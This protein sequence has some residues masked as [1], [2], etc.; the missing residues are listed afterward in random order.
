M[1]IDCVDRMYGRL[2]GE[3]VHPYLA[4]RLLIHKSPS[5]SKVRAVARKT[6][7]RQKGSW[8]EQQPHRSSSPVVIAKGWKRVLIGCVEKVLVGVLC[9]QYCSSGPVVIATGWK[10]DNR[11]W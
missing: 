6:N 2:C 10:R 7:R 9:Q 1:L 8:W 11:V 4:K 3:L 5:Q